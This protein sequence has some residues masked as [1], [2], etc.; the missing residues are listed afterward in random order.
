MKW[1]KK[2][3]LKNKKS[4]TQ[5]TF[6]VN[7]EELRQLFEKCSDI[8]FQKVYVHNTEGLLLF[9]IGMIDSP[10]LNDHVLPA[11][12]QFFQKNNIPLLSRDRDILDKLQLQDATIIYT[13][14]EVIKKIFS[15]YGI[16]FF[17]DEGLLLAVNM[18]RKPQREPEESGMEI[19]IKGSRDNFVE[20][21]A[22]NMALIRKR[23]PTNSLR[24][25]E[26]TVGR[27]SKTAIKVLYIDDIVDREIL[28]QIINSIQKIDIDAI[29][30]GHQFMQLVDKKL[31]LF[32]THD[33]SPRADWIVKALLSGRIILLIDNIPYAVI[34]PINFM[35]LLKGA[36][37][38][39]YPS[40]YVSFG[41]II[42]LFAIGIASFLPGFW[43]AI[44]SFHQ[45]QLPIAMLATVIES[46][47][48]IPLA[49]AVEALIMLLLFELFREAGLRLPVQ[50]G[51]TLSVVGGLI[52]GDAAIRAGLTSPS[53]LVVIAASSVAIF[54]LINQSLVG[55]VGLI[56][57][58]VLI[59]SSFF[60]F[61]GFFLSVF[62]VTLYLANIRVFG[63]PYLQLAT[64][65][66]LANTIKSFFQLPPTLERK[67]PN[68]FHSRDTTRR[69]K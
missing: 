28:D 42:R 57:F 69:E 18:E 22:I 66:S 24:S 4:I 15:G 67:R 41:R 60:G 26:M 33:Y 53:M 17:E 1:R 30:S 12:E 21:I 9:C 36:E 20:D 31:Y 62:S 61:F 7:E 51:Q 63:V 2:Y 48:G 56:R 54:T 8:H 6:E 52:I 68:M 43:V 13:K 49:G 37:D 65:I 39:E 29:Y 25:E 3:D 16:F 19:A 44:T 59:I 10:Y 47:K 50:V 45:S 32:P 55:I 46:R 40:L 23:L 34:V 11:F 14:E 35:L 64:R 27:R 5:N 38:S 58:F